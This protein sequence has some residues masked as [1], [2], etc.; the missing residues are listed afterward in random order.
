MVGD[1][2]FDN[3][4]LEDKTLID[5]IPNENPS[6]IE[7]EVV[8]EDISDDIDAIV[9]DVPKPKTEEDKVKHRYTN[10]DV[11]MTK[12]PRGDLPLDEKDKREPL[13]VVTLTNSELADFIGQQ[14]FNINIDSAGEQYLEALRNGI[15]LTLNDDTM[16]RAIDNGGEF[17]Q[18]VTHEDNNLHAT[19]PLYKS[20]E[21]LTGFKAIAKMQRTT[22]QGSFLTFP[23]WASGIW[24]TI[25]APTTFELADYYDAVGAEIIELGKQTGGATYG[26]TS[27]YLAKY[28]MDLVEKLV[29]KS[30]VKDLEKNDVQLRDVLIIDDMQTIAWAIGTCMYPNGYPFEEP[31]TVDIEKCSHVYKTILNISKMF[32]VNRKRL[33]NWQLQFMSNKTAKRSRDEVLKYQLDADWLKSESVGYNGFKVLI[34]SPTIGEH[35]NAG[36]RWIADVE[37]SIRQTLNNLSDTK[38]NKLMIERAGLTLLRSYSHYVKAFVYDD[39]STVNNLTDID[40]TINNLCTS[41]DIVTKFTA[42]MEAHISKS[43]ISMIAIPRHKC[44]NCQKDSQVDDQTHPHLIPIDGLQ[45]FFA[46]RDQKLQLM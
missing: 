27:V 35:I 25:R 3:D 7:E 38:L 5:I 46:L 10:P 41:P 16:E 19:V 24:I 18:T 15:S 42:D 4:E 39:G 1:D 30:S 14:T 44:P 8:D 12:N 43:T 20:G 6:G 34:K 37:Q 11:T 28:L 9:E 23:C 32:W 26:N 33:T 2:N 31:C 22:N 40:A 45:L 36:Y 17:V 21:N 29:Y 13:G